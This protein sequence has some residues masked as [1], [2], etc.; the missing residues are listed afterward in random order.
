M[1]M[2]GSITKSMTTMLAASL[3][4][5]G[6]VTWETRLIDLLPAFA[7]GD[8]ALTERLT[9]RDAFCNCSGV[10]GLNMESSF[11]SGSLT[12]EKVV[13]A[14]ADVAP[15]ARYGEQFIYNNILIATGGYALGVATRRW[16]RRPRPGLRRGVARA[17]SR[18][19][20]DDAL[21]IRS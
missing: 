4:D 1:M 15:T 21:E 18:P 20:R 12:P 2:I 11:E 14:L 9:V 16:R 8:P 10:P 13:T 17:D 3:V 5:H 19:D 7:V 6:R